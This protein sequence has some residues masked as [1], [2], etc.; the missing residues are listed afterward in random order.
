MTA[1]RPRWGIKSAGVTNRGITVYSW[2]L[3]PRRLGPWPVFGAP[4]EAVSFSNRNSA[5]IAWLTFYGR[6]P[7]G[8]RYIADRIPEAPPTLLE[9]K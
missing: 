6:R 9:E 5:E 7:D 8:R 4:R 3:G 1:G 2:W